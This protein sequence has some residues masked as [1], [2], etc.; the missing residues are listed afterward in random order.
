MTYVPLYDNVV[1]KLSRQDDKTASG[2]IIP[3]KSQDKPTRGEVVAVGEGRPLENGTLRAMRVKVGDT[4]LFKGYAPTEIP[5]E[6]DLV[7]IGE[8]DIL[9]I[10]Q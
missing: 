5:G 4:V 9:A 6:E 8:S 7:V 3:D 2:I 10:V 1:V